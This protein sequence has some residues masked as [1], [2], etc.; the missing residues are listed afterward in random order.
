M[1]CMDSFIQFLRSS[2]QIQGLQP[3]KNVGVASNKGK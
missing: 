1:F 3:G 2:L